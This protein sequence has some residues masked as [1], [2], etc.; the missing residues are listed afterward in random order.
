MTFLSIVL[1]AVSVQVTY[2]K[3]IGWENDNGG[4]FAVSSNSGAYTVNYE[5]YY[6]FGI[7]L[8]HREVWRDANNNTSSGN[9][10]S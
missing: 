10:C 4:G 7:A 6:F 9:P 8:D 1:I 2:A 5:T 3:V